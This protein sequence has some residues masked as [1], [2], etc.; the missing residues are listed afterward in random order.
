MKRYIAVIAAIMIVAMGH[1]ETVPLKAKQTVPQIQKVACVGNS[2]TYGAGVENR[3]QNCYPAV[4]GRMLGPRYDV[5]NFGRSGATLLSRGHNPYIKTE[6][7]AA[8]LAFAPDIAVI[9]LGINDTDPRNWPNYRD[10]FIPDYAALI[11]SFR[12][13]NPKCRVYICLMTPISHRHSRFKS[14][15]RLWHSQI[16][17]AIRIVAKSQDTPLIDLHSA[18]YGRPEL[19]PDTV[20]P[21]A[22]GAEILA[23]TIY[24]ALSGDYGDLS[25]SPLYS[26]NM[27]LQRSGSTQISGIANVGDPVRITIEHTKSNTAKQPKKQRISPIID[28]TIVATI[29]GKWDVRLRLADTATCLTLAIS[30]PTRSLSYRNVAIGQVWVLAGQSNMSLAVSQT[31]TPATARPNDRIRLFRCDP[32]FEL[33]GEQDSTSLARLNTLDYIRC[34]Q[35]SAATAE[36]VSQFSAVGYYFG[37]VL[38]DSLGGEAIG[39]V[40]TSL[41]GANAESFVARDILENDPALVDILYSP[42]T[43]DMIQEWCR[44]IM[45]QNLVGSTNPQ[46][47]HFFDPCYM[48]ESRILPISD[49][50]IE[51]VLWYQG[52]SNAHNVELHERLFPAV[53]RSFR[54][55]WK[56]PSMPFYF[57]QLSSHDR[58]SWPHFRDSQ[59]RM[60]EEIDGCAMVVCSDIGDSLDVHPRQKQLVG[61]RLARIAL[62]VNYLR[63]DRIEHLNPKVDDYAV[64]ISDNTQQR[65]TIAFDVALA[66]NN[67]VR[68]IEVAGEDRIFRPAD[69]AY[70]Q[71]NEIIVYSHSSVPIRHARYGWKPYYRTDVF[72]ESG[73]LPISTF[74]VV[75]TPPIVFY[76]TYTPESE[77]QAK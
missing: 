67:A 58:P 36:Q 15:T 54:Q 42:R 30:T 26:N 63:F 47:R 52:E 31:A 6:E 24:S 8:A 4:L 69:S 21:N 20:H 43:N 9:H 16:Q 57:V 49:Y 45:N 3:Q 2:I 35:W 60:A 17:D 46:Q 40:Q 53:V 64:V 22:E 66:P 73:L 76:D 75:V 23:Q 65:I 1:A 37:Q 55:A 68:Y 33:Q 28:T 51:G 62:S 71:G 11:D 50:S 13:A 14:G 48:Y 39:L 32:T 34:D 27:V 18:L 25:M 70:T 19:I 74:E 5:R 38:C 7:Y 59:R 10:S 61:E 29:H 56:R 44:Q 72:S 41:G 12:K 77:E